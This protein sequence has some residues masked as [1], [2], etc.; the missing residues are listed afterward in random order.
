MSEREIGV[1]QAR[2]IL[3]NLVDDA[4]LEGTTTYLTRR[5]RR[6]A[7]IVPL[8]SVKELTMFTVEIQASDDN[9]EIWQA[10][11]PAE[12]VPAEDF[13]D[14]MTR[15]DIA[16]AIGCNQN[17]ADGRNWRVCVWEGADA[18]TN[19]EPAAVYEP[20]SYTETYHPHRDGLA[21][22]ALPVEL[23]AQ[24]ADADPTVAQEVAD[25][26][27]AKIQEHGVVL[28]TGEWLGDWSTVKIVRDILDRRPT[29][30]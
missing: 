5:G 8:S 23:D 25:A 16:A 27:T 15:Q 11:A 1:E 13:G 20:I 12:N 10:M 6:Y 26:I 29:G 4:A 19:T 17:I 21:D 14:D 18:D 22:L 30:A 7:A 28:G 9:Q 3:G 24:L 2:G